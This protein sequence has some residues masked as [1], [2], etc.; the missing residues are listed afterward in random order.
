MAR[1]AAEHVAIPGECLRRSGLRRCYLSR[2]STA[3]LPSSGSG[4][5]SARRSG[6]VLSFAISTFRKAKCPASGNAVC[7]MGLY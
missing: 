1:S 4:P 3:P 6:R 2:F 7:I 5:N